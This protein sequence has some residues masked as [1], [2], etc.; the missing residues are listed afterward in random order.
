LDQRTALARIT[1]IAKEDIEPG[2][3]LCITYVNPQLR[4]RSRQN[5]LEAW[6]FGKCTCAR[7]VKEEKEE[8]IKEQQKQR[9]KSESGTT[10]EDANGEEKEEMDMAV[11]EK[12]LKAGLGVM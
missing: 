3:E 9:T 8:R 7:C 6:G 10:A 2:E 11:L 4:V 1:V 5:E 12:E